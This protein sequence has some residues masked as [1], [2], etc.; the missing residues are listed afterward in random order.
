MKFKSLSLQ[1]LPVQFFTTAPSSLVDLLP[2]I[3]HHKTSSA[4][5]LPPLTTK[6]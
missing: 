4:K 3:D 5:T 6:S 1:N 2:F